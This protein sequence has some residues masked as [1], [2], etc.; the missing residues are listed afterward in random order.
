LETNK[1]E[2]ERGSAVVF[3]L[4]MV[5]NL[6]NYLYQ[7]VMGK[8]LT[9]A[10]FGTLNVL[11]SFTVIVSVPAGV[12]QFMVVKFV[13]HYQALKQRLNVSM[14]VRLVLK[15]GFALSVAVFLLGAAL[16]KPVAHLM[17]IERTGYVIATFAAA[18]MSYITPPL[19]GALQGQKRF[20]A[21]SMTSILSTLGKLIGGVGF[22]LLGFGLY[23]NL[24][25]I[26]LGAVAA[27]VYGCIILKKELVKPQEPGVP[28]D[29]RNMV[30]Y[31]KSVI[32]VQL[33]TALL[34]NGDILLVK[35]FAPTPED[36]GIYASGM[37][38]GKI[39]MYMSGAVVSALFPMVAERQAHGQSTL[40]LLG[41]G[42]LLGGGLC[43]L[44]ALGIN[45]FGKPIILLLFDQRYAQAIPILLPISCYIV[46]IMFVTVLINYLTA[47][48]ETGFLSLS[49]GVSM[50]SIFVVIW[51]YHN[52]IS[53]MLYTMAMILLAALLVNVFAMLRRAKE[54]NTNE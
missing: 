13:A 49:L 45:L 1:R 18:A 31:M 52:S 5:V 48:G 10:D 47:R 24:I 32:W 42:M 50:L 15:I 29:R 53:Q 30:A 9:T 25:G 3:I 28:I 26:W 35:A 33:I 4:T 27:I 17:Q 7:L 11:L 40:P 6:C 39:S 23:G 16:S 8:L 2:L 12:L 19:S 44:C 36:V 51:F 43:A 46:V 22:V 54:L 21:F 37:I 14:T 41:R 34:A 20:A 38:I